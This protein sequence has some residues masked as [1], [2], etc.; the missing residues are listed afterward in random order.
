MI[1]LAS[2]KFYLRSGFR[3]L[4]VHSLIWE[5]T[6]V[7]LKAIVLI[8]IFLNTKQPRQAAAAHGTSL[9]E[10]LFYAD[11]QGYTFIL[12]LE[13]WY[14]LKCTMVFK[15]NPQKNTSCVFTTDSL[16]TNLAFIAKFVVHLSPNG[17]LCRHACLQFISLQ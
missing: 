2:R 9:S 16:R 8:F 12:L 3:Y 11:S 1:N 7:H 14:K 4:N 5:F 15:N 13:K 6:L 17:C 10:C